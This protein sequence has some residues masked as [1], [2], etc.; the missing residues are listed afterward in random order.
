M[1]SSLVIDYMQQLFDG[2]NVAIAYIYCDYRRQ[3][4]QTPTNLIASVTKQLLHGCASIPEVI[5]KKYQYHKDK[6]TRPSSAEVL[7]T[8]ASSMAPFSRIYLILDALD[9]LG[10]EGHV[11]QTLI[12]RLCTLKDLRHFNLLTTSRYIPSLASEIRQ[13]LCLDVRASSEDIKRYVEGHILD[14]RNCVRKDHDL[15][16]TVVGA[17]VDAVDGMYVAALPRGFC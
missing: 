6:G 11:R 14:L 9:E 8:T 13:P 2:V 10:N 5:M 17:I 1:L 15:Q 16:Q 7:E 4:E 12:E 3:D